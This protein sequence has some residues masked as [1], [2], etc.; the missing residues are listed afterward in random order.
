MSDTVHIVNPFT[1]S[2]RYETKLS[3]RERE[4]VSS[5]DCMTLNIFYHCHYGWDRLADD[6]RCYYRYGLQSN[7][8]KVNC[9]LKM[10]L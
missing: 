8:I 4:M 10:F 6:L 2:L 5:I 1:F 7:E 9:D 3:G